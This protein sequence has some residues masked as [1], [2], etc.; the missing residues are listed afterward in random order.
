MS[1]AFVIIYCKLSPDRVF[2]LAENNF[3]FFSK[4]KV[5]PITGH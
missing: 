5:H 4:L 1:E 3:L 2:R